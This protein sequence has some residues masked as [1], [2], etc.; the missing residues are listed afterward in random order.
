MQENGARIV[1]MSWGQSFSMAEKDLELNGVGKDA[2][3]RKRLARQIFSIVRD[4]LYTAMQ[5]A[6][7]IVFVTGS[8]NFGNDVE[9]DE[10]I[11]SSFDLPNLLVVGAADKYGEVAGFSG[12][13]SNVDIYAPGVDVQSRIPGGDILNMSGVSIAAPAAT[14]LAA[15]LLAVEPGLSPAQVIDIIIN[16]A[17]AGEQDSVLL[18]N[19]LGS[20]ALTTKRD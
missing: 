12:E 16:G 18:I 20:I 19:P 6:S 5:E 17:T 15:K 1:N 13:K 4:T 10:L 9:F 8:T 11:P 7:E 3:D 14:N 2:D